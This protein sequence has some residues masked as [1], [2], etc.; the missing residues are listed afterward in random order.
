MQEAEPNSKASGHGHLGES[1]GVQHVARC[2]SVPREG[3]PEA[4]CAVQSNGLL[5][6]L[7]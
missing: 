2:S 4:F 1:A 3:G 7:M 6:M 5:R